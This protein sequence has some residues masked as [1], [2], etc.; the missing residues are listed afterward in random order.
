M[1]A[2]VVD[3]RLIVPTAEH[4]QVDQGAYQDGT[5]IVLPTVGAR[6]DLWV[7]VQGRVSRAT[8]TLTVRVPSGG[9]DRVLHEFGYFA[10]DRTTPV[11][12]ARPASAAALRVATTDQWTTAPPVSWVYPGPGVDQ[13]RLRVTVT[14]AWGV[15]GTRVRPG[16]TTGTFTH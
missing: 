6:A 13:L 14:G 3:G 1:R 12:P 16:P 7:P 4:W 2:A 5:A 8:F 10:R 9:D 15:P 11:T